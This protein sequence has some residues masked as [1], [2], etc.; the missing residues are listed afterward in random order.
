VRRDL[1]LG[2]LAAQ[3]VHAAGESSPGEVPHSTHAVVL[4]V[5]GEPQLRAV[6]SRLS[7]AGIA[8]TLI[9]EPDAPWCGAAM[10]IGIAPCRKEVVRRQL[11]ALPLLR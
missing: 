3:V 2:L 11:S 4:A 9:E 8:H 6:A 10:A 1:P 7:G 5:D